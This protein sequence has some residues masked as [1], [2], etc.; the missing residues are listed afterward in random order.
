MIYWVPE[1]IT[2]PQGHLV[3]DLP[4]PDV[5][6]AWRLTVLASTQNG[7]LGEATT[8]LPVR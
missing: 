5:P 6:T 1:A 8:I 3:V 2:D 4:F 7:E